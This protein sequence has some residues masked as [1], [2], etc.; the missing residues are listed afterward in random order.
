[1]DLFC[2]GRKLN[3][4]REL[5]NLHGWCHN[6]I[7][8]SDYQGP[9][10]QFIAESNSGSDYALPIT[11]YENNTFTADI[12]GIPK[13]QTY[14]GKIVE[15]NSGS[16]V[17]SNNI[18]FRLVDA[19][20]ETEIPI[21]PL[22]ILPISQYTCVV[23][24]NS[25]YSPSLDEAHYNDA[26]KLHFYFMSSN[27]PPYLKESQINNGV[28]FCH[29]VEHYGLKD[30]PRR[31]RL[32]LIPQHFALWDLSDTRF[33]N[34]NN[35][36]LDINDALSQRL[37][38]K[39]GIRRQFNLF[40]P[41]TARSN[42]SA[43]NASVLGHI[44]NFWTRR[45]STETFCPKQHD[46]NG[47]NPIFRVLKDYIGIDT[48][49]IYIATNNSDNGSGTSQVPPDLLY[50]REGQLKEIWFVIED[51][52]LLRPNESNLDSKDIMFYWPPDP[53]APYTKKDNQ[54][55]YTLI[56][57]TTPNTFSSSDKKIGCIPV[58]D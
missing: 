3:L 35:E 31:E 58:S 50:I 36:T 40:A 56:N 44:M 20:E 10:C 13:D 11:V 4:H 16:Y 45:N 57:S 38:Q 18:Q 21:G 15:V 27:S 55:L 25:R 19:P 48:E 1:M 37:A 7:T 47:N 43:E 2:S 14:I 32:E 6:D 33:L 28:M 39:F 52:K 29:D 54:E 26:F 46:Y 23:R 22:K 17:S 42:P 53:Y 24:P 12:S 51:G 49:G 8:G 34:G 41:L 30:S 5:G 9:G